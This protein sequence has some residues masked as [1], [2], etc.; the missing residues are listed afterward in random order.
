MRK[1]KKTDNYSNSNLP[2]APYPKLPILGHL[3]LLKPP[4]HRS[5]HSLSLKHGPIFTLQLGVRRAVVVSS[6]SAVEEC[7]TRNDV[8]LANRPGTMAGKYIGYNYTIVTGSPYGDHWRNLRRICSLELF[9][10]A[11][12]AAFQSVRREET[13]FLLKNLLQISSQGIGAAVELKSKFSQLSFNVML[14]MIGGK[15]CYGVEEDG[16]AENFRELIKEVV[17]YGGASNPCD[18]IPFLRWIDYK[19]METNLKRVSEKMDSFLQ[20]LVDEHRRDSGR[21][22]MINHL[23]SMQD[24]QPEYYTDQI[25]KGLMMVML[26]V[27]SDTTAATMEWALSILLNHPTVLHKARSEIDGVVGPDRVMDEDDLPKLK[28]LQNIITETLRLFPAAPLLVPHYSSAD[29]KIGGYDVPRGTMLLVNAWAIHRD[30]NLWE[31]PT[32]FRPERFDG[33]EH[34]EVTE[35][36]PFGMGRRSC[37]GAGLARRVM[38]L[39]LGSMIQCF[40]WER[41]GAGEVDLGEGVGVTLFKA[42]PLVAKCK[43]RRF[44]HSILV[45]HN[46]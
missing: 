18:F 43:P 36:L 5:L 17:K 6:P 32:S 41:V 13:G 34:V 14:R 3:H 45:S 37:P 10:A 7:F 15:R 40:E 38:G 4:M 33:G 26:L 42:E 29:C 27:G 11:R 1:K 2:P 23:L 9:S 16:E 30:P 44:A 20:G 8:V 25:I 21:N 31:D 46:T 24:S 35:L 28:Y 19:K 22:S 12:L 39:A